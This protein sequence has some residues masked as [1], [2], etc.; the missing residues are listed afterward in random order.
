LLSIQLTRGLLP[1]RA[2]SYAHAWDR[3]RGIFAFINPLDRVS[4]LSRIVH[5]DEVPIDVYDQ[6]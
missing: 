4:T 1:E 5:D 6:D 3:G 2:K